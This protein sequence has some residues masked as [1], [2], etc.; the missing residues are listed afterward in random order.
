MPRMQSKPDDLGTE[1]V[2]AAFTGASMVKIPVVIYH[3]E[4]RNAVKPEYLSTKTVK[5]RG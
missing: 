3:E 4:I 2:G 1:A 5:E